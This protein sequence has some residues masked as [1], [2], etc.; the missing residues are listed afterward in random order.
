MRRRESAKYRITTTLVAIAALVVAGMASAGVCR[1]GE[2]AAAGED[3]E[4]LTAP[5]EIPFI[6]TEQFDI[7]LSASLR[8]EVPDASVRIIS[9]VSPDSVPERLDRWLYAVKR[10]GGEVTV[11]PDPERVGQEK[12]IG[13]ILVSIVVRGYQLIR[14]A[15]RYAPA[16][17]YNVQVMYDPSDGHLTRVVFNR[18]PEPPDDPD[19]TLRRLAEDPGPGFQLEGKTP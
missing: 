18:K 19:K 3:P 9:R 4:G 5:P 8:E 12:I 7:T 6:D 17:D 13:D 15:F 14:D 16:M 1:A 2:T 10:L 11:T